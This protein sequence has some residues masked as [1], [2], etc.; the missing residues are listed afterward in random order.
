MS[1]T[2]HTPAVVDSTPDRFPNPGLPPHR[3]RRADVD[4]RAARRAT[5]QVVTMFTL[6]ALGSIAFLV[7]YY[8]IDPQT[9]G[10]IIGIGRINLFHAVLGVTMGI[11]LLGI[12]LG[13]VHWARTLMPDEEV[14]ED[15]HPPAASE[16]DKQ[17]VARQ[18]SHGWRGSQLNRR[19]AI[20]GSAGGALGL[21][22]LP[23]V[24]P[25]LAG[26]GPRPRGELY[27]TNWQSG[28][29][30]M[31]DPSGAPIRA[32]DVTQ[33]SV[34]HVMPEGFVGAAAHELDPEEMMISKGKDQIILVRL[35][36]A[37]IKSQK[38]RDWGV[39]GIVA[40]SKVC[41]HVG[42]PVALYEQ[43]THH[44]LCPCHQSTFDM[45]DDC[46]VIFGPAKRPLPQLPITVDDEGYIVAADGF[47]EPVG[48]S[49][50]ERN[51]PGL[52]KGDDA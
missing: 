48:P 47:R 13:A 20:L 31:I 1:T 19:S 6:S 39:D 42:C 52:L 25:V 51:R 18:L 23:L 43:N 40:Y 15:R 12:G 45:T 28:M 34:F 46:K 41:T 33:G 7:A 5:L 27:E 4:E 17:A 16:E 50:F 29:R 21:F 36:P 8:V 44:L 9:R 2:D 26:L 32:A 14:S 38:Q 49:F 30:L 37:K 35:D 22:A 24:V 10:T 11:S 3:P